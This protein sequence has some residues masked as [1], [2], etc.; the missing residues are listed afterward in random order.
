MVQVVKS[1][2]LD[3]YW[4]LNSVKIIGFLSWVNNPAIIQCLLDF[5]GLLVGGWIMILQLACSYFVCTC[6]HAHIYYARACTLSICK[7]FQ[8]CYQQ[9]THMYHY[10]T[11]SNALY[12]IQRSFVNLRVLDRPSYFIHPTVSYSQNVKTYVLVSTG[13]LSWIID[14]I[15]TRLLLNS[16]IQDFYWILN[17]IHWIFQPR[18]SVISTGFSNIG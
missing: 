18:F 6:T 9:H 1:S 7:I 5:T 12:I 3:F 2:E 4:I 14:W 8:Y 15:I 10:D 17:I 16:I 13:L 11:I